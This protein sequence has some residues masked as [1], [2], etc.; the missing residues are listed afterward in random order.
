MWEF[1]GGK[2][3]PG[4]TA[5]SALIREI[6]E[7]LCVEIAVGTALAP[8]PWQYERAPIR[9]LPFHC[10]IIGGRPLPIE[11]ERLCWCAPRDFWKLSWAP[12]D[13]PV[14]EQIRR[15]CTAQST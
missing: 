6:R 15:K 9:L 7:E 11:H 3:E 13:L 14:L 8:V 12:A 1:P 4:E 2:V 5:H 10:A